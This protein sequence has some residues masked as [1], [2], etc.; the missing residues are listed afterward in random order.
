MGVLARSAPVA[1]TIHGAA[2]VVKPETG[3]QKPETVLQWKI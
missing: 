2:G 1:A 3:N